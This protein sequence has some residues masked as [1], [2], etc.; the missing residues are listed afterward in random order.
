MDDDNDQEL[1]NGEPEL[2]ALDQAE[3]PFLNDILLAVMA[4]DGEVYV[5]VVPFCE[6]L[7]LGSP[8]HQIRNIR[9][10]E[11]RREAAIRAGAARDQG[12][13]PLLIGILSS[14]MADQ[15]L[16]EQAIFSLGLIGGRDAMDALI[17]S[18]AYRAIMKKWSIQSGLVAKATVYSDGGS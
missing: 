5:P 1:I 15:G 2:D 14:G 18:G 8:K 10:D 3:I 11:D 9:A 12:A 17:K 13:V 7:G 16:M 4:N 6:H